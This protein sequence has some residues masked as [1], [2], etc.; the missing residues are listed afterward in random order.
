MQSSDRL[1]VDSGASH[2]GHDPSHSHSHLGH[3]D[4][5]TLQLTVADD[6]GNSKHTKPNLTVRQRLR[7]VMNRIGWIAMNIVT[8]SVSFGVTVAVILFVV[9]AA[10]ELLQ[11]YSS[12]VSPVAR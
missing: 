9:F 2:L 3:D 12:Q 6:D 8:L 1:Q 5:E 10:Y 11:R 4:D 7:F